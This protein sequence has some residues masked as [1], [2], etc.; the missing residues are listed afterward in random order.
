MAEPDRPDSPTASPTASSQTSDA[1]AGSATAVGQTRSRSP[2][3][4]DTITLRDLLREGHARA[5]RT[6]SQVADVRCQV[7]DERLHLI[8]T[9]LVAH[10]ALSQVLRTLGLPARTSLSDSIEDALVAQ[11]ITRK[12]ARILKAVNRDGNSAKHD[13]PE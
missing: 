4:R 6:D 10:E 8:H 13:L 12:E 7:A 5:F 3:R 2:P 11:V 1:A 9:Q